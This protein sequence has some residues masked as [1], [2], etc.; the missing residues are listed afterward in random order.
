MRHE[1]KYQGRKHALLKN[2]K[3]I[4]AFLRAVDKC[5]GDVMVRS[6]D[7]TE[8]FNLKSLISRCIA[9]GKL[10]DEGGDLYEFFVMQPSDEI[11]FF[12]FFNEIHKD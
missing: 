7:E 10:C 6:C 1:E 12:E 8:E 5:D 2:V 9:L 3:D 4:E 11:H